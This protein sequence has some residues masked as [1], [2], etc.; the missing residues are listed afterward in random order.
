MFCPCFWI[1]LSTQC[2]GDSSVRASSLGK[3]GGGKQ[4]KNLAPLSP[5]S[6]EPY[7]ELASRL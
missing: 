1:T 4:E 5:P 3:S 2:F 6:P 7:R